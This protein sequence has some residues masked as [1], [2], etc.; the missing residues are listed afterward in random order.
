MFL[1]ISHGVLCSKIVLQCKV[2]W[3]RIPYYLYYVTLKKMLFTILLKKKKQ[4]HQNFKNY[5]S[6]LIEVKKKYI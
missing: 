2:D 5:N 4:V 1:C 6:Y 3:E